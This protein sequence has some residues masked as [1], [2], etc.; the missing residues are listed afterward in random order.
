MKTIK[1]TAKLFGAAAF[2]SLMT[3]GTSAVSEA[4][5]NEEAIANCQPLEVSVYFRPGE[6][7]LNEFA[8]SLLNKAMYQVDHCEISRVEVFG[9]ADASGSA[10][11]N[12]LISQARAEVTVDYL[13]RHGMEPNSIVM[14]AKG[15]EG[16][17]GPD[18]QAEVMRRK[19]DI[20][21][22]PTQNAA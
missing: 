20:R 2:V 14:E 11:A 16:A 7:E 10:D 18:G 21:L 12:M 19:T 3:L 6:A 4:H 5:L 17:I 1:D 8:E 15:E 13:T 22:I 9:Y